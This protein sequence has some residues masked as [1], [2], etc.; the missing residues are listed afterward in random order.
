MKRI[1]S[2]IICLALITVVLPLQSLNIFAAT[3][4][5][6]TRASDGTVLA[7]ES[8]VLKVEFD[9]VS[10]IESSEGFYYPNLRFTVTFKD[11]SIKK[12]PYGD[13]RIDGQY[14]YSSDNSGELQYNEPW[15]AGNSYTVTGTILGVSD[16][17]TVTILKPPVESIV[18][19]DKV[20]Y[21]GIDSYYGDYDVP[22]TLYKI[23]LTDGTFVEAIDNMFYYGGNYYWPNNNSIEL[24]AEEPWKVGNTYKVTGSL[25]NVTDTF[26]VR[27][28]NNPIDELVLIKLPD[29]TEYIVGESVDL[30]GAVIRIKFTD[31]TYEDLVIDE[32][33]TSGYRKTFYS[34]K[35]DRYDT[36]YLSG[37]FEE[38]GLYT[39]EIELFQST[40][41]IPVT[42]SD[43]LIESISIKENSDKSITITAKKSDNTSVDMKLL[44][45]A[46]IWPGDEGEYYTCF[47]TDKGQFYGTVYADDSSFAIGLE[48]YNED[49]YT[50][51]VNVKSNHIAASEWF[52][53]M[54]YM[55]SNPI[56]TVSQIS[57]M[58][59]NFDGKITA[60]NI[61]GIIE[62]AGSL[63]A[64]WH[65]DDKIISWS[66]EYDVFEA[67]VVEEMVEKYFAVSDFDISLSKNYD[68]ETDTYKHYEYF[69]LIGE[70]MK[71]CPDKVSFSNSV[72][73]IVTTSEFVEHDVR[74]YVRLNNELKIVGLGVNVAYTT[75]DCNGDG[76][77]DTTD[78]AEMKLFLAGL[79]E[80]TGVAELGAD[81][82]QDGSVDTTDLASLKLKL[83][84][85]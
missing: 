57:Y 67:D 27:I 10:I 60:N 19:E 21:E 51:N 85:L 78:L 61:D 42:V 53:V 44:D 84:G 14:Y 58:F 72:W 52:K 5:D 26:N 65:D 12:C 71:R 24:Q 39:V 40:L 45:L 46:Y 59:D 76:N 22:S 18:L 69:L 1:L 23:M 49:D 54:N 83:A 4:G 20:L 17:F 48:L 3:S 28:L 36:L 8:Y 15:K 35:I 56:Y 43:N 6:C 29:K 13:L 75:G 33:C 31:G 34:E 70:I 80:L 41:T 9:D 55:Y 16:T 32:G 30:K 11:G 62:I 77:V 79:N 63:G 64:L 50:T 66:N 82:N 73:T 25:F 68:K 74:I 47:Y 81:L 2:I 37:T 7:P 38:V